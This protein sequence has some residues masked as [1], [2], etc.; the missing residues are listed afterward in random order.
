MN[1]IQTQ[2]ITLHPSLMIQREDGKSY[3]ILIDEDRGHMAGE[4]AKSALLNQSVI[5][6]Q[7]VRGYENY[8]WFPNFFDV[9][10]RRNC[11]LGVYDLLQVD[12]ESL[13]KYAKYQVAKDGSIH[14]NIPDAVAFIKTL[15]SLKFGQSV[16]IDTIA[17]TPGGSIWTK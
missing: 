10:E 4:I 12:E 8:F 15:L 1:C 9:E 13:M 14:V 2:E 3:T 7:D 11:T 6:G 16:K 5:I 17:L